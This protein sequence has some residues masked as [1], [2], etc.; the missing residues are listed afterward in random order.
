MPINNDDEDDNNN[1]MKNC[2]D[3]YGNLD[4]DHNSITKSLFSL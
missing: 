2:N 4:D 3:F 1:C